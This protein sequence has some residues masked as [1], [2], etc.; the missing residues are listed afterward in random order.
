[1]NDGAGLEMWEAAG[2]GEGK[3]GFHLGDAGGWEAVWSV[4]LPN[5]PLHVRFSPDGSLFATAAKAELPHLRCI[6]G[7][8]GH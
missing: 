3:G 7:G 6:L 1:M 8:R 5:P 4:A 2:P